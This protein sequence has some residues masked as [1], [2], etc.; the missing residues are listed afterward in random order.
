MWPNTRREQPQG[1]QE[2]RHRLL[3]RDDQ[4]SYDAMTFR[5]DPHESE[6][7]TYSIPQVPPHTHTFSRTDTYE[8][9]TNSLHMIMCAILRIHTSAAGAGLGLLKIDSTDHV[10]S[11]PIMIGCHTAARACEQEEGKRTRVREPAA[12]AN[13]QS[14]GLQHVFFSSPSFLPSFPELSSPTAVIQQQ[15]CQSMPECGLRD[16]AFNFVWLRS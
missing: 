7:H 2:P 4:D 9:R 13:A 10:L 8:I 12:H 6:L 1:M 5:R 11:I 14:R 3:I 15:H 16:W